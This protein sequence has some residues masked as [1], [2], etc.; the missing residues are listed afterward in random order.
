MRKP[1]LH[2]L[3][4]FAISLISLSCATSRTVGLAPED[5]P[6]WG[7]YTACASTAGYFSVVEGVQITVFMTGGNGDQT[8]WWYFHGDGDLKLDFKNKDA[9]IEFLLLPSKS[10]ITEPIKFFV[11]QKITKKHPDVPKGM[12]IKYDFDKKVVLFGEDKNIWGG[13]G[14]REFIAKG[15][16]K[17][18]R[19]FNRAEVPPLVNGQPDTGYERVEMHGTFPLGNIFKQND[20]FTSLEVRLPEFFLNGRR[21]EPVQLKFNYSNQINAHRSRN[22]I[23]WQRHFPG[24]LSVFFHRMNP[25]KD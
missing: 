7:N 14:P 13:L 9:Q 23:F 22:C 4:A 16:L 3:I 5:K 19:F 25:F 24:A 21:V 10:K 6:G 18:P 17:A 2:L 11:N 8:L 20:G 1:A 15:E 12:D